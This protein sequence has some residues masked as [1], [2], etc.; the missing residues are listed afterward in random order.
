MPYF[1]L[2]NDN[3][4]A[5][6]SSLQAAGDDAWLVMCLC[7]DWCNTCK[8]YQAPFAQLAAQ[9]AQQYPA[10]HFVWLD[11]EDHADVMGDI[12]IENFPTLLLQKGQETA[13]FGTMLPEISLAQRLLEVQLHTDAAQIRKQDAAILDRA[14]LR[15]LRT[16]LTLPSEDGN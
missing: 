3:R 2:H 11:I 13:F 10:M 15:Q 6:A 9:F 4:A 1:T 5:L 8:S 7:A 14:D 12:D 16:L